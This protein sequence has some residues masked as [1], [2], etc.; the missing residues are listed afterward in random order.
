MKSYFLTML[1]ESEN[2]IGPVPA[3]LNEVAEECS[4]ASPLPDSQLVNVM[5]TWHLYWQPRP[6]FGR[7]PQCR[8]TMISC[9]AYTPLRFSPNGTL[10][11]LCAQQ[12][13]TLF[14]QLT[15]RGLWLEKRLRRDTRDKAG[16]L[17]K[18]TGGG[19]PHLS[20]KEVSLSFL[21]TLHREG[22][23][24]KTANS[25]KLQWRKERL[26]LIKCHYHSSGLCNQ[27]LINKVS[28]AL[29]AAPGEY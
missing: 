4:A 26:R 10:A 9:L 21:S 2:Q 29:Q 14:Q 6:G 28:S 3:T 8:H 18:W 12:R 24:R 16:L 20:Q 23:G 27:S 5:S 7:L 19:S 17:T 11:V 1:S 15:A 25:C 13:R 22:E